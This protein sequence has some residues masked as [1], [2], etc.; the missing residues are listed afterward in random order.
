MATTDKRV[1]N[2]PK[3]ISDKI[4]RHNQAIFT[5]QHL[6]LEIEQWCEKN[7]IDTTS[8]EYVAAKASVEDAVSAIDA[9][10]I[11]ELY[12]KGKE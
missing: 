11:R 3:S 6:A 4:K 9:A 10:A 8:E 7:G 5:A 1:V 12:Q 2:L